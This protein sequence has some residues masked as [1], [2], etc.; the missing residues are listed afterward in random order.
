MNFLLL[1]VH[2]IPADLHTRRTE[3]EMVLFISLNCRFL[4]GKNGTVRLGRQLPLTSFPETK[5]SFTLSYINIAGPT[6][7]GSHQLESEIGIVSD[8]IPNV[9]EYGLVATRFLLDMQFYALFYPTEMLLFDDHVVFPISLYA[10]EDKFSFSGNRGLSF[11]LVRGVD[12]P[13]FIHR[14]FQANAVIFPRAFDHAIHSDLRL[15][16]VEGFHGGVRHVGANVFLFPDD[17]ICFFFWG[18]YARDGPKAEAAI[19]AVSTVFVS[20][21][22]HDWL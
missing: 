3:V 17:S 1:V 6:V 22:V 11:Y 14:Y 5:L 10:I 13:H 20:H 8:T 19:E 7:F 9:L 18:R 16:E 12:N 4:F 15:S 2:D 21:R